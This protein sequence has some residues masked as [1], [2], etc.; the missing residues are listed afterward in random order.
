[1]LP[2]LQW[3][4]SFDVPK[5][6]IAAPA[7]PVPTAPRRWVNRPFAGDWVAMLDA[8]HPVL[9][10]AVRE[11]T[12]DPAM[13]GEFSAT[14]V[15][16]IT[17]WLPKMALLEAMC[18]DSRS[19]LTSALPGF[20]VVL[21]R[22]W[23]T[24]QTHAQAQEVVGSGDP[25]VVIAGRLARRTWNRRSWS[26]HGL[27]PLPVM[28]WLAALADRDVIREMLI[29]TA[30]DP[31]VVACALLVGEP[32]DVLLRQA[33]R[34]D[35]VAADALQMVVD[36]TDAPARL[37]AAAVRDLL[38]AGDARLVTAAVAADV[39]GDDEVSAVFAAAAPVL[40]AAMLDG[41]TRLEVMERLAVSWE[42]RYA[43]GWTVTQRGMVL[44]ALDRFAGL[45]AVAR[46]RLVRAL[47]SAELLREFERQ[48][49][50]GRVWSDAEIVSALRDQFAGTHVH[51]KVMRRP[52]KSRYAVETSAQMWFVWARCA[53]GAYFGNERGA[54][55]VVGRFIAE[56]C[57][58]SL[59]RVAG[60]EGS[61]AAAAVREAIDRVCGSTGRV[62]ELFEILAV[63]RDL[64][65][66][67]LERQARAAAGVCSSTAMV[68]VFAGLLP[69]WD[70][71]VEELAETAASVV[72]T[73][74]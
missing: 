47:T 19:C 18:A 29:R 23:F 55:P 44:R 20:G 35:D 57:P 59:G 71:S 51:D 1:M 46:V 37:S 6:E 38:T 45:S 54:G 52:S 70:G 5:R 11:V 69:D 26:S 14:A 66:G 58:V 17:G 73:A 24:P 48:T 2:L 67:V 7:G 10:A 21:D 60:C 3:A 27:C 50:S 53:S 72:L 43:R 41:V 13:I 30:Q 9:A 33:G 31:I 25:A 12:R 61:L 68:E 32:L 74:R 56:R 64:P 15:K 63:H 65:V 22:A 62:R 16:Q 28:S 34:D 8:A 40:Q 49:T 39:L 36:L 4:P 42:F